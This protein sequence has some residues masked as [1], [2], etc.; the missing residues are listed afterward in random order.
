MDVVERDEATPTPSETPESITV[1][2]RTCQWDGQESVAAP[3]RATEEATEG[4]RPPL[5]RVFPA[6]CGEVSRVLAFVEAAVLACGLPPSRWAALAMAVDEAFTNIVSYAY[7][8]AAGDIVLE[9]IAPSTDSAPTVC[10]GDTLDEP[11]IGVR[12]CDFGVPFDPLASSSEIDVSLP[13]AERRLGGLGIVM[14]RNLV[15][16]VEYTRRE[17]QNVLTLWIAAPLT[18]SGS[19]PQ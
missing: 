5:C 18:H 16:H 12:F 9:V 8:D 17:D 6:Q 13:L 14:I 7:G 3:L 11:M 10:R 2:E 19:G 1:R 4:E 15:D